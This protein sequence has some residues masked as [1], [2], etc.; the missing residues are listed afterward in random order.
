MSEKSQMAFKCIKVIPHA[1]GNHYV[2]RILPFIFICG[3]FGIMSCAFAFAVVA[4]GYCGINSLGWMEGVPNDKLI[5]TYSLLLFAGIFLLGD[6]LLWYTFILYITKKEVWFADGFLYYRRSLFGFA[7]ERKIPKDKIRDFEIRWAGNFGK[8]TFL[9]LYVNHF[10]GGK[11]ILMKKGGYWTRPI[12]TGVMAKDLHFLEDTFK[13][14]ISR[15]DEAQMPPDLKTL[16]EANLSLR[17]KVLRA[18][19]IFVGILSLGGTLISIAIQHIPVSKYIGYSKESIGLMIF[20]ILFLPFGFTITQMGNIRLP[21]A[22]WSSKL[23]EV[24]REY[25]RFFEILKIYPVSTSLLICVF[26]HAVYMYFMAANNSDSF[27]AVSSIFFALTAFVN[28][29]IFLF[30]KAMTGR[31]E[32][33]ISMKTVEKKT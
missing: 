8:K 17:N 21:K 12:V 7:W 22:T 15:T 29:R 25:G 32:K 16:V 5:S 2:I 27:L 28:I 13:K 4:L 30:G 33:D 23:P 9:H 14:E 11:R 18:T 6:L 31:R 10:A 3:I 26:I 24:F 20:L 1:E 19:H